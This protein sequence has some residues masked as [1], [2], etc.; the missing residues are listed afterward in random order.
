MFRWLFCIKYDLLNI[1]EEA[2]EIFIPMLVPWIPL[3]IWF[4]PRLRVLIIKNGDSSSGRSTFLMI[5]GF[6]LVISSIISQNY[7][8]TATGNLTVLDN[9]NKMLNQPKS[10]YYI[11][12]NF[13][14]PFGGGS[15]SDFSISG[16]HNE[17]F[18]M[19]I[20]F[21]SPILVNPKE[22]PSEIPKY[23]YGVKYQE[24]ISNKLSSEEKDTIYKSFYNNCLDKMK[25]YNFYQLN[26]FE[27]IPDSKDKEGYIKAITARVK[28][29]V[30]ERFVVLIP[31]Q[32]KYEERNGNKFAWIFGSFGIG[33]GV[34]LLILI[35]PHFSEWEYRRFKKGIKPKNDDLIDALNYLVPKGNHII[36]SVILDL[37]ILIWLL[38]AF[39][40]VN[41]FSAQAP[42]LLEWGGN[43]R[44]DTTNGEWWRL[45]TNTF[46]HGG[47]M[48]LILN[49]SGL[50]IAALFIE[51]LFS[52]RNYVIIYVFSGIFASLS[53]I[54]WYSNTVS[55]G[56]SGAIF[57]LYGAIL[58]LAFT[59]VYSK[60]EQTL[61]F[62]L[63]GVNMAISLLWGL[64]GGI[65]NAAHIGG[66]ISGMFLGIILYH[67]TKNK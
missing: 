30:D 16:K 3:I 10:R 41:I 42:E 13:Y 26:Y 54:L 15:Y 39:S 60:A 2:W 65:D 31:K 12:K 58:G 66:L 27:R 50:V 14:V 32:D 4:R 46:I 11:L 45:L 48:H 1:K 59:K 36:T 55:V 64:T 38:M 56:A 25:L 40:G 18:N 61:V 33:L 9:A 6:A 44:F 62:S 21:V 29:N 57:G 52:K 43:R 20:Y 17:D 34:L 63:I 23:W 7:L 8:T 53:S 22:G 24:K 67:Y 5:S 28:Q 35:K 37:N 47:I 19:S 49:I 51:P